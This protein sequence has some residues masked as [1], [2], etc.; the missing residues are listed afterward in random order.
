MGSFLSSICSE[1]D[2]ISILKQIKTIEN[3]FNEINRKSTSN[4]QYE[5]KFEELVSKLKNPECTDV[6]DT[7]E[8]AKELLIKMR[9]NGDNSLNNI[10]TDIKELYIKIGNFLTNTTIREKQKQIIELKELEMRLL[11]ECSELMKEYSKDKTFKDPFMVEVFSELNDFKKYILDTKKIRSDSYF[12]EIENSIKN[13]DPNDK[14]SF[15]PSSKKLK[16]T[17]FNQNEKKLLKKKNNNNSSEYKPLLKIEQTLS[18]KLGLNNKQKKDRKLNK[19]LEEKFRN[20]LENN[21]TEEIIYQKNKTNFNNNQTEELFQKKKSSRKNIN[22]NNQ[23]E[24]VFKNK[25]NQETDTTKLNQINELSQRRR[26][27]AKKTENNNQ[28]ES[29]Y[30]D[31]KKEETNVNQTEELWKRKR[32]TETNVNQVN[33]SVKKDTKSNKEIKK[34]ITNSFKDILHLLKENADEQTFD[35]LV[36]MSQKI[37]P[38]GKKISFQENNNETEV[39]PHKDNVKFIKSSYKGKDK[40]GDFKWEI[41]GN[42]DPRTLYIFNDDVNLHKTSK[43]GKGESSIRQYNKYGQYRKRPFSAGISISDKVPFKDLTPKVKKIIDSDIKE[44][45]DL[46]E[47]Y[48]FKKIKYTVKPSDG[49]EPSIQKYILNELENI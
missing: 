44:I 43:K 34:E 11:K 45:K 30:K 13:I 28:F 1:S 47:Q 5:E 20:I 15:L 39:L 16:E 32:N 8:K 21:D 46:V 19:S 29:L 35:N 40:Y 37:K 24:N 41:E 14:E 10:E 9:Q 42:T 18:S 2:Y 23:L 4:I 6:Y 3:K 26:T 7:T 31:K 27:S 17:E 48:N 36:K 22:N 12:S 33:D 49:I 25:K 38:S